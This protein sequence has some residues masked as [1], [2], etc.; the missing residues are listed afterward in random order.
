MGLQE[1]YERY[2]KKR[3][4]Y[5]DIEKRLDAAY[6]EI[7]AIKTSHSSCRKTFKKTVD[8]CSKWK[9]ETL[10]SF[11]KLYDQLIS[12]VD[13]DY[14]EIDTIQDNINDEATE[15]IKQYNILWGICNDLWDLIQNPAN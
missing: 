12:A 14:T 15:A 3:D 7:S 9:G 13:D 4:R 5:K 6:D 11:E 10:K 8:G 1:D 2:R